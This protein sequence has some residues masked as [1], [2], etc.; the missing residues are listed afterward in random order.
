MLDMESIHAELWKEPSSSSVSKELQIVID[1]GTM[2][3]LDS[4]KEDPSHCWEH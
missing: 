4:R 2:F 1:N 3:A